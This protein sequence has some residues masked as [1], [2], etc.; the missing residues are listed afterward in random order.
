MSIEE[1]E[2]GQIYLWPHYLLVEFNFPQFAAQSEW[3]NQTI[4]VVLP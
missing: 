3:K 4:Y 2:Q 1:V